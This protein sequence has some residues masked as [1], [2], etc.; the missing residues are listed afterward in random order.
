MNDKYNFNNPENITQFLYNEFGVCGCCETMDVIQELIRFLEWVD[1]DKSPTFECLYQSQ[2][3]YYLIA[4]MCERSGLI[5][6]GIAIR[7]QFLTDLGIEF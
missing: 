7:C 4:R 6:H 2:G 5:E 1:N 3:I